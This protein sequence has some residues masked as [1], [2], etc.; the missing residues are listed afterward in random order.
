MK[1]QV[2]YTLLGI[3]Y[4]SADVEESLC[5]WLI[6][7]PTAWWH[8]PHTYFIVLVGLIFIL[9]GLAAVPYER[10]IDAVPP[11]FGLLL[12]MRS[13]ISRYLFF[14][15]TKLFW[16][17]VLFVSCSWFLLDTYLIFDDFYGFD[18]K[19]IPFKVAS[20]MQFGRTKTQGERL[21]FI[22]LPASIIAGWGFNFPWPW[23]LL[24]PLCSFLHFLTIFFVIVVRICPVNY[25]SLI[26]LSSIFIYVV[27]VANLFFYEQRYR[28]D[29]I[30]LRKTRFTK[31]FTEQLFNL[32]IKDIRGSIGEILQ[33][34]RKI[35]TVLAEQVIQGKLRS[36]STKL[37][38]HVGQFSKAH[39]LLQELYS[40]L[41]FHS[42][43][44]DEFF[45][46]SSVGISAPGKQYLEK[47]RA[48]QT[49]NLSRFLQGLCRSTYVYAHDSVPMTIYLD[50]DPSINLIIC[51]SEMLSMCCSNALNRISKLAQKLGSQRLSRGMA[52]RS[53]QV[54]LSVKPKVHK[55]K[56]KFNDYRLLIIEL[57]TNT[58]LDLDFNEATSL[59]SKNSRGVDDNSYRDHGVRPPGYYGD[60]ICKKVLQGLHE[61]SI[62]ECF[63]GG[64]PRG[65]TINSKSRDS[66]GLRGDE[67]AESKFN[68]YLMLRFSFPY[69]Q[70]P[71]R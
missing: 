1:F 34:N 69:F 46:E 58:L 2:K 44:S 54:T 12:V 36:F 51:D 55:E 60:V 67:L 50:I 33:T 37:G 8:T 62:F 16:I 40:E 4:F 71:E 7:S 61:D 30:L 19:E 5:R 63:D 24:L 10:P 64:A 70:H 3:P 57:H 66:Q 29:F 35:L 23:A 20:T 65:D 47:K 27:Q 11:L 22:K 13:Q 49:V 41:E 39:A 14:G 25:R 18:S 59:R 48:R 21:I 68:S 32:F 6:L 38:Y 17:L 31:S 43:I 9:M 28:K 45:G 52:T 53:F 56:L 15:R 42:C 26:F